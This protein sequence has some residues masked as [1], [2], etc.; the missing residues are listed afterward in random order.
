MMTSKT[1]PFSAVQLPR[2]Q[3]DNR[4]IGGGLPVIC[5]SESIIGSLR[6]G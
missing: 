6:N 5:D 3:L 4:F 2:G 1:Q